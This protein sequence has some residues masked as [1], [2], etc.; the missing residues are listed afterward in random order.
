MGYREIYGYDDDGEIELRH[1]FL[2][3]FINGE[4][5]EESK[6]FKNEA[7]V[8]ASPKFTEILDSLGLK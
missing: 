7:E 2:E 3:Y 8:K 1:S 6:L 5:I 4:W